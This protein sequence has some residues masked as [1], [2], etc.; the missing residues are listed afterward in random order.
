SHSRGSG[1]A[2]L[3]RRGAFR[4]RPRRKNPPPAISTAACQYQNVCLPPSFTKKIH[5]EQRKITACIFHHLVEVGPGFLNCD[6]I[7]FAHL[8]RVDRRNLDSAC[9][10]KAN[11]VSGCFHC[12][13]FTESCC[14]VLSLNL[15][16]AIRSSVPRDLA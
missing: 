3:P 14:Q 15:R 9:G 1:R 8:D 5:R 7:Y 11:C 12:S 2:V 16:F 6:S 10:Y 4:Q 13:F